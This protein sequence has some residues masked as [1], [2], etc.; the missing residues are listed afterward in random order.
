VQIRPAAF[1]NSATGL[2]SDD[3]EGVDSMAARDISRG[4]LGRRAKVGLGAALFVLFLGPVLAGTDGGRSLP[5]GDAAFAQAAS[6]PSEPRGLD[7][8]TQW[9]DRSLTRLN[10]SLKEAFAGFER[11]GHRTSDAVQ[12]AAGDVRHSAHAL[13][14]LPHTRIIDKRER[15]LPA[16]NGAPDCNR[17]ATNVCRRHGFASGRSFE[18][19]SEEKCSVEALLARNAGRPRQ[20]RSETYI[21]RAMCQ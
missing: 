13:S 20:C 17:A 14:A 16:A 3:H 19:S 8:V 9:F 18:S 4:W 5:L 1:R 10:D 21:L 12:D 2:M 6:R 15:C 11:F 7:R